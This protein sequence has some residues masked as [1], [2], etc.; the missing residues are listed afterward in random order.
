[1]SNLLESGWLQDIK[2]HLSNI[3]EQIEKNKQR[4]VQQ[5]PTSI[6]DNRVKQLLLEH[7]DLVHTIDLNKYKSAEM[8]EIA[9]N[10]QLALDN[11][12]KAM[13]STKMIISDLTNSLER[14]QESLNRF[15]M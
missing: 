12:T 13:I 8:K 3:D 14:T 4:K 15:K 5:K 10:N 7:P 11:L 2:K 9:I 1:M 6:E